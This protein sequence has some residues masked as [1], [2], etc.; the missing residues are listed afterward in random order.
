MEKRKPC[1]VEAVELGSIMKNNWLV[2]SNMAF[3]TVI[4]Y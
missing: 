1:N 4:S 3:M 2:V